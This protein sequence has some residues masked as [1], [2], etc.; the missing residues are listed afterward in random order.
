MTY[1]RFVTRSCAGV[2][3]MV[4]ALSVGLGAAQAQSDPRNLEGTWANL[5]TNSPFL[6]GDDLP[7]KPEGQNLAADRIAAFRAG[8][9]IA[10]AHLTCRPTGVQG[11]TAPKG[12]VL[13]VR[14]KTELVFIS[15]E[16]REVRRIF[17]N[18]TEHPKG[19]HPTY[20]GHSIGHWEGNTLVVDTVGFNAYGILDEAGNPHS[21]NMHLVERFT[22]S[23]DGKTLTNE[24]TVTDPTFYTAPFTR[25]RVWT[26]NPGVK[27]L[28]YDC[29][30]NPRADLFEIMSFDKDWFKPT[31]IR[32][33]VDGIASEKVACG[34]TYKA[35]DEHQ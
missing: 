32:D 9:T 16:D 26:R 10:N 2:L 5:P 29:A 18:E 1:S 3:G 25:K 20:S 33:V 12:P 27:L 8:K 19:L 28:D 22:L 17:M 7:Y 4:A 21:E 35:P 24:L 31:C 30:E 15:Q 23:D 34:V 13:V 6:I 14:T 11:F